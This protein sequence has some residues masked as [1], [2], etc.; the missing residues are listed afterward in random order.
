MGGRER[1][2]AL[3]DA[4]AERKKPWESICDLQKLKVY[5]SG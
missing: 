5:L 1:T 2:Q 4:K 3:K